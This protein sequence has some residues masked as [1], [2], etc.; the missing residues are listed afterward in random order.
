MPWTEIGEHALA[1]GLYPGLVATLA[2]GAVLEVAAGWAMVP[3]RGGPRV[4]GRTVLAVLRQTG[5]R[6]VPLLPALGVFL[7]LVAVLQT[8]IPFNPVPSEDRN[9]LVAAIGLAAA[10]WAAWGWGWGRDEIDPGL[11]LRV[12]LCWLVAVLVPALVPQ[13]LHPGALG[14]RQLGSYLPIKFACGLLFLACMPALIQLLPESAPVGVPGAIR[15]RNGDRDSAG[16]E[17]LRAALWLPYCALF[18]S[19]FFPPAEDLLGALRFAVIAAGAAA[20]TM[21]GAKTL[22][23]QG[24]VFTRR[25]YS[26]LVLPFSL[27]TL[28]LGTLASILRV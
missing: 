27:L 6:A 3:E 9:L 16:M 17:V 10:G 4:A 23:Y 24:G 20:L 19:L 21:A 22:I 26:F 2:I 5:P 28:G 7:A 11:L 12:Q 8:S 14:V 1:L 15:P 13:N 18:A 25:F